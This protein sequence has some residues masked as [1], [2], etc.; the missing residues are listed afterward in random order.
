MA[1]KSL[2][3]EQLER[4]LESAGMPWA[5]AENSM[6]ALTEDQRVLR[7]GVAPPPGEM[8]VEAAAHAFEEGLSAVVPPGTDIGAPSKIDHRALNG[9]N[10]TTPVKNQGSCGSCVAFAT[11]A[12]METTYKRKS[13]Q[14]SLAFD[15]SEAQMFYCHARS[16]GRTCANG[17]WPENAFKK[18]RDIGITHDVH[19]PYTPGDQDCSGLDA[20]WQA[21]MAKVVGYQK[22]T[23]PADMKNWLATHGSISG[24]FVVYQDFFSYSSGVYRHVS[25]E[26]AGGHCVE[27]IGYDDALGCWICKNSWGPNWGDSGYFKIAYGQCSIETWSGPWGLTNV[28]A[29]QWRT[30]VKVTGLWANSADLNSWAY[31]SGV[32]WRKVCDDSRTVSETMLAQLTFAKAAGTSISA[33][34]DA[35]ELREI[36]A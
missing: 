25:G 10:Y 7:L 23:S 30:N 15:L 1:R 16:E 32:G 22:L 33:L 24:C 6:T 31:L 8:T 19:Y 2:D 3:L 26:A 28:S 4:D 29:R 17:W 27:I 14:P 11:V 5:R 34:D 18:A 13:N 20:N 21:D 35:N 36:Y 9:N 12:V